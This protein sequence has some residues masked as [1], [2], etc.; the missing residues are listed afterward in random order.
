[1]KDGNRNQRA[2]YRSITPQE[3]ASGYCTKPFLQECREHELGVIV[4][5]T[6]RLSWYEVLLL[7]QGWVE[8]KRDDGDVPVKNYFGS[9]SGLRLRLR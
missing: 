2:L 7:I 9:T 1:M 3:C 8:L 4:T 6:Q 5:V